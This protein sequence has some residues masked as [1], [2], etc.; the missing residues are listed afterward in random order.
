MNG[1]KL[2]TRDRNRFGRGG[3]GGGGLMFYLN[4]EIPCKFLSNY[5]IFPNAGIISIEPHQLK[6]KWLLLGCYNPPIQSDLEFI[7]PITKIV[8]FYL[9]KFENFFII[10]DLYM[11]T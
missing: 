6:S 10:A 8:D 5:S 1:Y 7:A 3:E 2:F 9:Q 4:T 11:T